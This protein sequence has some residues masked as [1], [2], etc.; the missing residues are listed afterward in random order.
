MSLFNNP[1]NSLNK[2]CSNCKRTLPKISDFWYRDRNKFDYFRSECKECSTKRK[3]GYYKKNKKYYKDYGQTPEAKFQAYKSRAKTKGFRFDLTL[4]DFK[5]YW[6]K[7]C[8]YCG[9]KINTIGLDRVNNNKGYQ[10]N[11]V[12]PC[13]STCNMMKR[14]LGVTDWLDH[15]GKIIEHMK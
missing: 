10:K 3:K 7:D 5:G 13:C 14:C 4:K 9:D 6:K 1:L 15:M 12:V 2:T 11:N 8:S